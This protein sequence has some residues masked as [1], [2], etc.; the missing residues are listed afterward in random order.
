MCVHWILSQVDNDNHA[1]KLFLYFI[2]F[3]NSLTVAQFQLIRN[4]GAAYISFFSFYISSYVSFFFI[5]YFILHPSFPLL[6]YCRALGNW[7][8]MTSSLLLTPYPG[9]ATRVLLA[10]IMIFNSHSQT[11]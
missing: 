2:Q 5:L 4:I 10:T 7:E 9:K 6:D 3:E 8:V 1:V 11:D